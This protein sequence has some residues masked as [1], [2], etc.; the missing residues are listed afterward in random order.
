M[1][2]GSLVIRA[3]GNSS[4]VGEMDFQFREVYTFQEGYLGRFIVAGGLQ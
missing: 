3:I 1:I 4:P 2:I